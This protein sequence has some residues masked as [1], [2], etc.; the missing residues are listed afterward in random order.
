M[1]IQVRFLHPEEFMSS[2]PVNYEILPVFR[3]SLIFE[4]AGEVS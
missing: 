1:S 2:H 4:M 3:A